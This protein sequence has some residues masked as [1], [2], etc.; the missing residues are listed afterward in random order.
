MLDFATKGILIEEMYWHEM[1]DFSE[2]CVLLVL[3]SENYDENDYI[4]DYQEFL[5]VV[6]G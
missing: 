1:H 2:G 6:N 4:R 3:A 5:K